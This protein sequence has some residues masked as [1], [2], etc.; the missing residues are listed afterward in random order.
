M[1]MSYLKEKS[2][3]N[4]DAAD[5]LHT[6]NLYAPSV[7]CSYYSCLQILKVTIN[8]FLEISYKD[9]E[10]EIKEAKKQHYNTHA[11]IIKKI[12]DEIRN[13]SSEEHTMFNRNIKDLKKFRE[14]SDYEDVQITTDESIKA[15]NLAKDLKQQIKNIFNI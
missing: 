5:Y 15:F 3:F 12:G 2:N 13:F 4:L 6:K 1:T 7:H 9:L 8:E 11:Y 10:L 14:K